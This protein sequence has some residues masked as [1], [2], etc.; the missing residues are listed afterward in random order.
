MMIGQNP[1]DALSFED[2]NIASGEEDGLLA[3][4]EL[5]EDAMRT[6][7]VLGQIRQMVDEDPDSAATLIS[8]WM[9]ED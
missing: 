4:L 2:S 9:Q 7:Q 8:R 5:G 6:Q 3:G 1:V